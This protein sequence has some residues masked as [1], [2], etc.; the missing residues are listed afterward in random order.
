M[1]LA[2]NAST[3]NDKDIMAPS[4]NEHCGDLKLYSHSNNKDLHWPLEA[5]YEHDYILPFL[6]SESQEYVSNVQTCMYVLQMAGHLFPL[7]VNDAEY[8]NSYVC[9]P[10][11][12]YI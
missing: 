5:Q 2:E 10:F 8:D 9:S 3:L 7:T 12:K 1:N 4:T 6:L 11:T